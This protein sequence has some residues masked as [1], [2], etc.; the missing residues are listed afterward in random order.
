M[1]KLRKNKKIINFIIINSYLTLSLLSNIKGPYYAI[2]QLVM[3]KV[4]TAS[5]TTPSTSRG[6]QHLSPKDHEAIALFEKAVEK[7][8]SGLMSDAVEYYR[9]AFKINEQVDALYRS[10]KLP[11]AI[12]KLKSEKGKNITKRIDEEK[13][14]AIN[15]DQLLE[16]F[17][18][19]DANA[20]DPNNPE[21]NEITIKFANLGLDN[22]EEVVTKPVSPL[23]HLPNDIWI[24]IL[25]QLIQESPESWF[26]MSITCKKFA[27]LGFASS[28]IWRKLSC[29]I[30][31]NQI[32]EENK[33][34]LANLSFDQEIDL[35][36]PQ[37]QLKILPQYNGSWKYMLHNR[38]FIKFLGCYISVVNYYSE[39]GR[40]EFSSSWSNPIRMITYYRYIRFY[41]NGDCVKVLTILPPDQVVPYL[42]RLNTQ[43][44]PESISETG[45]PIFSHYEKHGHKIYHGKWT[46]STTGEVHIEIENGSVDYCV[47][48][49]YFQVK[50]LGHI[51]KHAKLSW[52][53]YSTVR[54]KM[55]DDD[56][57]E[58]E[59]TFFSLRNEKPF[60]FLRVRSYLLDN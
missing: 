11:Q 6:S 3:S 56:D 2:T 37:D 49:Y 52:I 48:H 15:V 28:A 22:H 33:Q 21:H 41:P 44:I 42:L 35:P 45:N 59:V 29:L 26:S 47:F 19:V 36:I 10:Q 5:T 31:P 14:R 18:H 17:A 38:P 53:R 4:A 34:Y 43:G 12:H 1:E 20:P 58:G 46:M 50:S 51:N 39:G 9:K 25:T 54:K 7:E 30:Y 24:S 23:V 55:S 13:V 8:S 60:K 27:Y 40:T 32:Y 16:S 57:R